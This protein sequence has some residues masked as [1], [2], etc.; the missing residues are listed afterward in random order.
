MTKEQLV[1]EN[2]LLKS[3]IKRK[4]AE[5]SEL[6]HMHREIEKRM[7]EIFCDVAE[8]QKNTRWWHRFFS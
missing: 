4:D 8:Q 1:Q 5:I 6:I 7:G 2:R 3:V